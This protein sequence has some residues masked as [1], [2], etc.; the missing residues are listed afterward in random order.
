M[1]KIPDLNPSE[2]CFVDCPKEQLR[3]CSYYEYAR[4][5]EAIVEAMAS[6]DPDMV[7]AMQDA[8]RT[9]YVAV[10]AEGFPDTPWLDLPALERSRLIEL[11]R[12]AV[13]SLPGLLFEDLNCRFSTQLDWKAQFL[14]GGP[15]ICK[16][17]EHAV[18]LLQIDWQRS[19]P[20]LKAA[21]RKFLQE[22]RP[23]GTSRRRGRVGSP[24]D[25]LNTLGAKRLLDH[26]RLKKE[27][28]PVAEALEAVS[29]HI[30]TLPHI[31]RGPY[32]TA[33]SLTSAAKRPRKYLEGLYFFKN[34]DA[35][36]PGGQE[37]AEYWKLAHFS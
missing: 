16:S 19:N 8:P 5:C 34:K 1:A 11:F 23:T 20:E 6:L 27:K 28:S 21:F 9:G 13:P 33:A 36:Q 24:S 25:H 7:G 10:L 4:S 29:R 12:S 3:A 15:Y 31:Q 18:A 14:I 37:A 22:H 2:W 32:T 26:F 17:E 30:K 35:W